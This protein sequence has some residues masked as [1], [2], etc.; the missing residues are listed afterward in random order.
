MRRAGRTDANQREIVDAL[1]KAG[2]SV[3]V[4]S[5]LGGGFPDLVVG[6]RGKNYLMEIKRPKPGEPLLT[7]DETA[8]LEAWEGQAYVVTSVRQALAMLG[9]IK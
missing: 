7:E 5:S 4:T 3:H 9:A 6:F 8:F 2:A 1:R